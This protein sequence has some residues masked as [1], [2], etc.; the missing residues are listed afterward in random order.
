MGK[1][2]LWM[3]ICDLSNPFAHLVIP[4]VA[5]IAREADAEFENYLESPR[6][7]KLFA[8]T[9]STIL[10]GHHHQ[11]FNYLNAVYDVKYILFGETSV[12]RSSIRQFNAEVMVETASVDILYRSLLERAGI[13][14]PQ[15]VMLA[16]QAG[17]IQFIPVTGTRV[18][19]GNLEIGPYLCPEIFF[20][21]ALAFPA[22]MSQAASEFAADGRNVRKTY[23]YLSEEE[24][25]QAGD[26]VAGAVSIDTFRE[27]DT[28]ASLTLRIARRWKHKAKGVAFGDP[29]A[30]LSMLPTICREERVA[31]YGELQ[32]KPLSEV[33][34]AWYTE[35]HSVIA[36]DVGELAEEIGNRVIVGRQTGD[37]DLF[38]WSRRGVCM[39]IMDPNRPAFP[40]VKRVRHKWASQDNIY[41]EEP[42]DAELLRYAKEGKVLATLMW[43]SGEMAH[44]EAMLNLCELA[45]ITGVKMGIGV[46]AARYETCPQLWELLSVP[47]EKGGVKGLIE[48]VL[49]S[50]G[51]GVLA[52][53]NCPP[54]ILGEHCKQALAII[55]E[56][57]GEGNAPKGYLAFMDTDLGT[58]APANPEIYQAIASSGIEYVISSAVPGR[59][60]MLY[61]TGRCKVI[62]QS[63]RTIVNASPF[64]R[65]TTIEDIPE[66]DSKHR[67]AWMIAT[68]DAPVISF[69]SY[70]WK[71]GS[72]FMQIVHWLL[73]DPDTVN[74]TPNVIARYAKILKE[75]GFLPEE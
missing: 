37:G 70:I 39:Q 41:E 22:S 42:D 25:R 73:N 6:D 68:L 21:K 36:D 64:V 40:I 48:P 75:Q 29:S 1:K 34:V 67:P 65:V 23:L 4:T 63:S 69:N 18:Q 53:V 55:R 3:F 57:A 74:V 62:N 8:R 11:Q 71:Y 47:I 27:N 61:E 5:W 72:R 43:H 33:K 49:H 14:H 35:T 66:S 59:N 44:N 15:E 45:G 16:P 7:G 51:M 13:R 56:I 32:E 2:T 20:R 60:R 50:G 10:G 58:L 38:V 31:L 54:A 24:K 30:I 17:E 12:F 26:F 46:H 9:G 52:E 19:V 28:Y